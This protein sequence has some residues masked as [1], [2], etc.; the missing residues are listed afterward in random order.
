MWSLEPAI[1]T[2]RVVIYFAILLARHYVYILSNVC[3]LTSTKAEIYLFIQ[4]DIYQLRQYMYRSV[5]A[6]I[7][8][9]VKDM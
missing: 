7:N 9:R 6:I 2:M 1:I 8:T 5:C 3:S 4:K